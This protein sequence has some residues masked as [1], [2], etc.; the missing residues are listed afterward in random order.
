[1]GGEERRE[2]GGRRQKAL[3]VPLQA[4]VGKVVADSANES[5]GVLG[6]F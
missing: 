6:D 3:G 1:L 5:L 2:D 4:G